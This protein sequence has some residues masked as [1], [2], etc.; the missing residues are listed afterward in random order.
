MSNRL[1]WTPKLTHLTALLNWRP[2]AKG[3]RYS[4]RRFGQQKQLI[5]AEEALIV[6]SLEEAEGLETELKTDLAETRALNTQLV[7]PA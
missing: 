6:H 3:W 1:P 2:C 7:D 5:E 4:K